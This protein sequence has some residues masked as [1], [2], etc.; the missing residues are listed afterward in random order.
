MLWG[1]CL[2]HHRL[3]CSFEREITHGLRVTCIRRRRLFF[4][5][6][7]SLAGDLST[8]NVEGDS[9][10]HRGLAS[11]VRDSFRREINHSLRVW[12]FCP[13]WMS[14]RYGFRWNDFFV[15]SDAW[16]YLRRDRRKHLPR[17]SA[18]CSLQ[19]LDVIL[20]EKVIHQQKPRVNDLKTE[21]RTLLVLPHCPIT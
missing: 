4:R 18:T 11:F 1:H 19:V 10:G 20:T 5:V 9:A 21:S 14:R 15:E 13:E 8:R 7:F 16:D 2:R 17:S 12:R 3:E 6:R